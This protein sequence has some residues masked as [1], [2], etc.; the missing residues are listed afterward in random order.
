MSG[1]CGTAGRQSLMGEHYEANVAAATEALEAGA[2]DPIPLTTLGGPPLEMK[3]RSFLSIFGP[4]SKAVP[5]HWI[6]R[7]SL[8]VLACR[9]DTDSLTP[10][11]FHEELVGAAVGAGVAVTSEVIEDPDPTR[12]PVDAHRFNGLES[13][14]AD[15]FTGWLTGLPGREWR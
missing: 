13:A 9:A 7:V 14:T 8:P 6:R 11:Q 15:L 12:D 4:D 2:E 10:S 5:T 1:P 3:P